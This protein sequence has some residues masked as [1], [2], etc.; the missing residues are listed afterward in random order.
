MSKPH[1][2][3]FRIDAV[4]RYAQSKEK[5]VLP[6]LISPAFFFYLWVLL[7]LLLAGGVAAW[8]MVASSI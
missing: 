4:R 8:F 2:P 3:I 6:H 1:R 7:G 5:I